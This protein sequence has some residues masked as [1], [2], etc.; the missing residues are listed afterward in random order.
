[1]R[2]WR[3]RE[4][5]ARRHGRRWRSTRR[6]G[7]PA[8]AALDVFAL[9]PT[10]TAAAGAAERDRDAAPRRLDR[11][12]AGPVGVEAVRLVVEALAQ[13]PR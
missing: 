8:G 7:P 11:R 13:V 3:A 12:G 10:P 2:R 4:L 6:R 1:M 5:R 9:S